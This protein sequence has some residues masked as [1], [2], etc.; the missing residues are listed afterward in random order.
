MRTVPGCHDVRGLCS[1][2]CGFSAT[3]LRCGRRTGVPAGNEEVAT[4]RRMPR[5]TRRP[6]SGGGMRRPAPK[7]GP[8]QARQVHSCLASGFPTFT[9]PPS[10]ASLWPSHLCWDSHFVMAVSRHAEDATPTAAVRSDSKRASASARDTSATKVS[11]SRTLTNTCCHTGAFLFVCFSVFVRL[12]VCIC[13]FVCEC[14][15]LSTVCGIATLPSTFC[16]SRLW[17]VLPPPGPPPHI[18]HAYSFPKEDVGC[19]VPTCSC[20]PRRRLSRRRRSAQRSE[21]AA[22]AAPRRR[23]TAIAHLN[24]PASLT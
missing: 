21:R 24:G 22:A 6:E 9:I 19:L 17:A 11:T 15:F 8:P 2:L 4:R 18:P 7:P 10:K 12:F 14:I 13:V 20:E 16:L 5:G 1:S 23:T 3:Q